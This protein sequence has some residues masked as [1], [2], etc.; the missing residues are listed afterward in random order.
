MID[1]QAIL[2]SNM[3]EYLQQVSL[4]S[5]RNLAYIQEKTFQLLPNTRL[6]ELKNVKVKELLTRNRRWMKNLNYLM[7]S[8]DIDANALNISMASNIFQLLIWV[9]DD[10]VFNDDKDICL[11]KNFPHNKLVF[12][13]LLFPKPTLPCT[14]TIYWLYKYFTKYQAIYN[15]N[16]NIVPFHCFEKPNWDQCQFEALF[17][18]YCTDPDPDE[19]YTTLKPSTQVSFPSSTFSSSSATSSS[20]STAS[21]LSTRSTSST[22]SSEPFSTSNIMTFQPQRPETLQP[23]TITLVAFYLAISLSILAAFIIALLVVLFYKVIKIDQVPTQKRP[24]TRVSTILIENESPEIF[25]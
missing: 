16:Q 6:L 1:A 14:C 25:I 5:A 8:Y 17:N 22:S 23:S 19:S 11:F 12:P 2:N 10:W 4:K 13:F 20:G 24:K 15:L 21:T 3:F 9:D 18:R 7:P